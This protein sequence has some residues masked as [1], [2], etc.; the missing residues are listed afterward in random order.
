MEKQAIAMQA[1]ATG[2]EA[3]P[4]MPSLKLVD[5]IAVIFGLMVG[6]GIFSSAG[7]VYA[8]VGSA[9]MSLVIWLFTGLLALTGALCYAELG[10]MIPGSG[11]EAPYL[12]RGFGQWATF[13]FNWAS[14]LLLKPGGDAI[15]AVAFAKYSVM[16]FYSTRILTGQE[17]EALLASLKWIV[18]GVAV[19][20]VAAVTLISAVSKSANRRS[21]RVLTV[22]KLLSLAFVIVS[23]VVYMFGN[24]TYAVE[25]LAKPLQG[26]VWNV[27]L[28]ASAVNHG[29]WA[30]EG[31]N[32]L[33]L[34]A[35]DLK[36]PSKNL[37][38]AIWI[39]VCMVIVLYTLTLL[40][41]F[42]VLPGE[43]IARS[44]TIGVEFGRSIFGRAGAI[45]MPILIAICIFGACLS[46]MSTSAEIV[47]FAARAGHMPSVFG[48]VNRRL[49][50]ALN[51][52]LMQF[53]CA[54][55]LVLLSDFDVLVHIY[56]FPAWIFYGGSV[57]S[58]LVLRKTE[59]DLPRPYRVWLTTP[60]A[61]LVACVLLIASSFWSHP[62]PISISFA[63]LLLGLPI[64]YFCVRTDARFPIRRS[65]SQ[66][67]TTGDASDADQPGAK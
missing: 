65:S 58:L 45:V 48:R 66:L 9:G 23:G 5:G 63:V 28:Y 39:S 6:S 46:G 62:I 33:N 60:L 27:A 22:I 25:N 3:A 1:T 38:L 4:A 26:T 57:V 34:V 17:Q 16:T 51:A 41:Y 42:F 67:M 61:F 43:V 15:I 37:P 54:T 49:G 21:Q 14:C 20:C 2:P 31:W 10:T 11:G 59:P 55:V 52:Y 47:V 29:L 50:T 53:A 35:G 19:G 24:T 56:T 12:E 36:R 40:G 8:N 30:F 32:N 64:Y 7:L 13:I 44:E 18:K